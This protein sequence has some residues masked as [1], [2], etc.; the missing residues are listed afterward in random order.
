M[1]QVARAI[2]FSQAY[3]DNSILS[4]A[5]RHGAD[6]KR[7]FSLSDIF[8]HETFLIFLSLVTSRR[9]TPHSFFA[10]GSPNFGAPGI[11]ALCNAFG[12][13]VLVR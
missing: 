13:R 4:A 2:H 9:L 11:G 5:R 12:C 8:S 7:P 10:R 1:T 6:D 3:C